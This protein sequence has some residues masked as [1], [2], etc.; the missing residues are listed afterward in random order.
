MTQDVLSKKKEI[1]DSLDESKNLATALTAKLEGKRKQL[2]CIVGSTTQFEQTTNRLG[3]KIGDL[4]ERLLTLDAERDKIREQLQEVRIAELQ[5]LLRMT[6]SSYESE[7]ARRVKAEE[8]LTEWKSEMELASQDS[9]EK[10]VKLETEKADLCKKVA[11]LE[12]QVADLR[13]QVSAT[14]ALESEVTELRVQLS[15]TRDAPKT[16]H[17]MV[18]NLTKEIAALQE[19]STTND[20]LIAQL[21][22]QLEHQKKMNAS[23]L[24]E[25]EAFQ[26]AQ[27]S[28]V[29]AEC[30]TTP[31]PPTTAPSP[32]PAPP[33][34]QPQSPQPQPQSP[35]PPQKPVL[36]VEVEFPGSGKPLIVNLVTPDG[37]AHKAGVKVGDVLLKWNNNRI[38]SDKAGF[39]A[40]MTSHKIGDTISLDVKRGDSV[41]GLKVRL[42]VMGGQGSRP[43]H[44][45]R[46]GTPRAGITPRATPK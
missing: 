31:P 43:Q 41:K 14:A 39:H 38:P 11:T 27:N 45:A 36:G 35:K 26:E 7:M 3:K 37:P 32:E 4:D 42:D 23:L 18:Q 40:L 20:K 13:D 24:T 6:K 17:T 44:T 46:G 9:T 33:S 1:L 5:K 28:R 29:D 22:D 21:T 30:Q 15:A 10:V 16:D 2:E 25:I 12:S 19:H 8:K 34:P